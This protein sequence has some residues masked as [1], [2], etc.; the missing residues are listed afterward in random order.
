VLRKELPISLIIGIFSTILMYALYYVLEKFDFL[1]FSKFDLSIILLGVFIFSFVVSFVINHFLIFRQLQKM[2]SKFAEWPHGTFESH[3]TGQILNDLNNN[4]DAFYEGRLS[5]I[6]KLQRLETHRKEYIGNVSHELKT[7]IFNIQGYLET[8]LDGGL[9][10]K[11]VNVK[12]L[13]KASQS[14]QRMSQIVDDLQSISQFESDEMVLEKEDFDIV[15]LS[16]DVVEAMDLM[17]KQK[18]VA[19]VLSANNQEK[20]WVNADKF[21]IRRVLTNLMAN[22]INYN[23]PDG[24]VRVKFYELD[25]KVKVE[26]SDNGIG[27]AEQHIP[28]LFERFYRV[29]KHRSREH[30]GSGL[31]L[32]IV[33]HII[34]AHDQN[35]EVMST[36]NVGSVF[37]FT[38]NKR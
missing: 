34:E 22:A 20:I 30:G 33:K 17:A 23:K 10:D 24:E 16:K 27:I 9:E 8:L 11:D 15:A 6:N 31:G 29:D 5:E 19:L 7:P 12:F 32:S 28:R 14:T 4:L 2:N 36:S 38:L 25:R 1:Y 35:I 13:E 3:H 21:R 18:K 26:I 37:S